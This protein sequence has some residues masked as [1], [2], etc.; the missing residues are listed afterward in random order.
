MEPRPA[1]LI[2]L[3]GMTLPLPEKIVE[4]F[5]Y[6]ARVDSEVTEEEQA[7][8]DAIE[9]QILPLRAA[10]DGTGPDPEGKILGA[11]VGYYRHLERQS[12]PDQAA[13]LG[14]PI[15][16]MQGTR[17]YQVT[18]ADFALW[19]EKLDGKSFACLVAYDGLDHLFRQG[20][21]LSQPADY[22]EPTTFDATV[23][24]D[25]AGWIESRRCP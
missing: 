22:A 17:D 6:I 9:A 1:G 25:L 13:A 10:L 23:L 15:L 19:Q 8:I 14:L 21:G 16:V 18:M 11:P 5:R 3:A 2:V 24:D 4:Q 7:Q 20:E 12:P